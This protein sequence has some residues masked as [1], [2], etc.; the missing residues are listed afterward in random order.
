MGDVQGI[1]PALMHESKRSRHQV[2]V[3]TQ[4]AEH[5]LATV[6]ECMDQAP[7]EAQVLHAL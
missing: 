7:V 6:S 5:E 2:A 1:E 4:A 3:E